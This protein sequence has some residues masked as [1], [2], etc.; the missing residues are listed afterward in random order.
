MIS[1]I[2]TILAFL[3]FNF[4]KASIFMGSSGSYVIGSLMYFN[5]ITFSRM[6]LADFGVN[7]LNE[8]NEQIA[9]GMSKHFTVGETSDIYGQHGYLFIS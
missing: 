4:G 6:S 8:L 7:S 3:F 9:A 1:I 5:S 2:A